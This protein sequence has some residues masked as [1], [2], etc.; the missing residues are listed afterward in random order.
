[1]TSSP[2]ISIIIV[3]HGAKEVVRDCLA[4]VARENEHILEVIV[5]D[6]ASSDGV[7]EMIAAD[8]PFVQL[9]R[10]SAN[11]GFSPANNQGIALS[12]APYLLLLNPD[13]VLHPGVIGRW[14]HDHQTTDA[15]VSGPHLLN[16]DGSFQ[17]SA[18]KVPGVAASVL[19]LFNLHRI[20]GVGVYPEERY[21]TDF[22]PGFVSGAA[23]LFSRALV[24]TIGGLDPEMFW[25]EDVDLCVRVREAGGKVLYLHRPLVTHIGGQS[26]KKNLGRV[27]G[28]QL[29]SRMKFTRKH[30]GAAAY[31]VVSL[32][33]VLHIFTRTIAFGA[34]SIF[35][36]EPRFGAYRAA[37][38]KCHRY[39]FQDDRSI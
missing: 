31:F 36:N 38:R 11:I 33:T 14:L 27:I 12:T 37:W 39:L 6:N 8:F 15:T 19:E 34:I 22:T 26:S 17:R 2:V 20:F 3:T 24:D 1:M 10:N 23:M 29:V 4:S 32:A 30:G 28:N 35:R 18:W 25:M 5:V 7:P 16:A 21:S 13:T 9:V